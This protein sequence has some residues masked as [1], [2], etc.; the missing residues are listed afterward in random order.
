MTRRDAIRNFA[1][2]LAGS[3]LLQAQGEGAPTP[4]QIV[5]VFDLEPL[6]KANVL[7]R[8]FDYIS[9]AAWD[10]R[11][12]RRNQEAFHEIQLLPRFLNKVDELDLS[13]EIFG[14]RRP[15]PIFVAPMAGHSQLTPEGERATARAAGSV[16]ALMAVSSNS[17]Y[18]IGDI[19]AAATDTLWF[20]LYPGQRE[21]DTRERIDK[22][23]A[24]GCKAIAWTVDAPYPAPRE[25]DARNRIAEARGSS[26][27]PRPQR[28]R[29]TR[30]PSPYGIDSVAQGFLDWSFLEK[31]KTWSGAPVLIKGI[32][33]PRDAVLAAERGADGVIVSNHG[34][35]YLDGAPSTIEML[36]SV[37][38][39]VAGRIPVL[40]DSGFRRG[41]D[42]VKALAIGA[43]AVFIGRPVLWG[44]GAFGQEGAETALRIVLKET[45]W[46][47]A[48]AG[49]RD[50]VSLGPDMI[51]YLGDRRSR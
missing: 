6:C 25:R 18:P 44:L 5:N 49:R 31:V 12:M 46:A 10:E 26:S 40:I 21:Q 3:P 32:L 34:G 47:M 51:R 42:V 16:G 20:Q 2:F 41:T 28:R 50:V 13:I 8:A 33:D 11:T 7:K 30:P 37:V 24:A 17:S 9:G 36:P 38:D 43:K 1:A 35:R 29:P 27:A 14:E 39:A 19:G 23:M 45:A 4:E 22:A 48:L 15:F